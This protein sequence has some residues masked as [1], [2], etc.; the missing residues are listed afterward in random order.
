MFV[1]VFNGAIALGALLGGLAAD[2]VGI[3]AVMWLGAALAVGALVTA[4][5]DRAPAD[6]KL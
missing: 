5:A 6:G 4:G 1:G 2:G 3:K